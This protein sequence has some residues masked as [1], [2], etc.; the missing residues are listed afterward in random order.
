MIS[1]ITYIVHTL[2]YITLHY[3]TLHYITLHYITL[4]Y[5]TLHT[6]IHTFSQAQTCRPAAARA[7]RT[8][9]SPGATRGPRL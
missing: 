9:A 2:H 5:I 1:S 8:R 3:I 7:R 4:H 6:Y